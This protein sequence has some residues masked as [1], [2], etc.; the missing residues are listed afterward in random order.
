MNP[1]ISIRLWLC[2]VVF[3][4]HYRTVFVSSFYQGFVNKTN[5]SDIIDDSA[6]TAN[7]LHA[8]ELHAR[9]ALQFCDDGWCSLQSLCNDRRFNSE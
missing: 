9:E 1:A 3:G 6:N 4:R 2:N 7:V 5:F 8:I